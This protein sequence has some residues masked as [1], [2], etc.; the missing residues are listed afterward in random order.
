MVF[1]VF[2][3][4]RKWKKQINGA[5]D[6]FLS[7]SSGKKGVDLW[8]RQ[9]V[10]SVKGYVFKQHLEVSHWWRPCYVSEIFYIVWHIWTSEWMNEMKE[11]YVSQS[12]QLESWLCKKWINVSP[13]V[14]IFLSRLFLFPTHL[15]F[16]LY[17]SLR[18]LSIVHPRV[19]LG[20]ATESI[21]REW[22]KHKTGTTPQ[23]V[24]CDVAKHDWTSLV[25]MFRILLTAWCTP[26]AY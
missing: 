19:Q 14:L 10:L 18:H 20:S 2:H 3:S 25:I 22:L 8:I 24:M 21:N 12:L 15:L 11:L 17:Q 6:H 9:H 26:V 4:Y 23:Y 13:K 1:A 16:I 5:W 7:E